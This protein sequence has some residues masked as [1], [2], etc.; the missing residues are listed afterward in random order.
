MIPHIRK[1]YN[2]RFTR[3]KYRAFLNEI[4]TA[5]NYRPT[6]P[7]AETPVFLP[8]YLIRL[9]MEATDEVTGVLCRP[10]FRQLSEGAMRPEFFVPGETNHPA[11]VCIDF[12]ICESADGSLIPQLIEVQGFPSLFYYQNITANAYR[13]H[14]DI[15]GDMDHLFGNI[16]EEVYFDLLR[17]IIVGGAKPENVVL[18]DIDPYSQNT[19]VDFWAASR[20]LG[21]KVIC[22]SDLKTAG[23]D[24]FYINEDGKKIAVERIF[25]RVIFDE[26]IRHAHL[27]REF[28][29]QKEYNIHWVGHPNWFLRISKH[30]LPFFNSRFVPPSFY[31][32]DENLPTDLDHYVLKPLFSF[33]G[34]GVI[35]GPS[36]ADLAAIPVEQRH[37][38][39]LQK[40]V[41]YA[42]SV[43]TPDGPAMAEFR[44]MMAWEEEAENPVALTNLVRLSKGKMV[45]VRY[46]KGKT[47]VGGSVGFF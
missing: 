23:K 16:T 39:I 31:L 15:P 19:Q 2:A 30:T 13:H 32:N 22:L 12:G 9:I 5:A 20:A 41:S 8:P 10:D 42:R 34:Q 18:L 1:E 38:Y 14:F 26:L 24:V 21:I 6:F 11:F 17:R 27:K 28:Y 36:E 43:E 33:S 47:W 3:E 37:N 29:F 46:N 25:N 40:K 44:V 4:A 45:G 7:I 35:I